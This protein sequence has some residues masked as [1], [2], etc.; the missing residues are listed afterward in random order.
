VKGVYNGIHR[1]T[2]NNVSDVNGVHTNSVD[3]FLFR[4]GQK[5]NPM[6]FSSANYS[7]SL[8]HQHDNGTLYIQ[9]HAAGA[10]MYRYSTNWGSSF[11]DWQ[12][13][14][15]GNVTTPELPWSGTKLQGWDGKHIRVE[16]FSR[17]SGS[18]DYV[19]EGD[20]NWDSNLPRRF[21]HLFWNG[22]YNQYGYDAG[23]KNQMVLDSSDQ[24]WKLSF[25]TE[26]PAEVQV[27]V[28]GMNP[29]GKPDQT[30]VFGDADGDAVLDRLPPSSLSAVVINI[31]THPPSPYLGWAIHINDGT[32]KF[33]LLPIGSQYAQMALFVLLWIVP[34]LTAAAGIYIFMK[35]FYQVKFVLHDRVYYLRD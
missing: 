6:I 10:D 9:H 26:W 13:Y 8:L 28:W 22:P 24:M 27:N 7:S 21:P 34:V 17:L 23:L 25:L 30:G 11:S 2:F 33:E 14:K 31:T 19:Q 5:D 16:Y 29:D 20:V 32:L 18:S 3:H 35:S 1:M 12:T 15:G 4:T